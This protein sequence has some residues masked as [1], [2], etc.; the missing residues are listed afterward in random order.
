MSLDA[1]VSDPHL[2]AEAIGA[3]IGGALGSWRAIKRGFR[4]LRAD[5]N[6]L[7]EKVRATDRRVTA[8]EG[9]VRDLFDTV[10]RIAHRVGEDTGATPAAGLPLPPSPT[11]KGQQP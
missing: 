3:G 11:P 2:W 4:T 6:A 8:L 9:D 7:G 1:L 5:I 10:R